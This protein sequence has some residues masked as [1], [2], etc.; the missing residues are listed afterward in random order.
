MY[1]KQALVDLNVLNFERLKWGGV[2][3]L[4][5]EYALLD[6]RL[7]LQSP[8]SAP[9]PTDIAIFWEIIGACRE[10]GDEVSSSTLHKHLPRSLRG[11]KAEKDTLV[12]ILGFTGILGT[13]AHPGFGSSFV[14]ASARELPNRR[15]VDMSYPACWWSGAEGV[16][17]K[18]VMDF[19]GYIAQ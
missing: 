5:V 1:V 18:A 19:F 8:A 10:A 12:A 13:S 11:N 4:H 6:L 17:E 9:T 2:R 14:P 16:N 3:H 15:F 7:F